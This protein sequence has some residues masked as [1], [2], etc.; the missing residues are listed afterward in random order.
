MNIKKNLGKCCV[1]LLLNHHLFILSNSHQKENA[2]YI[3]K[4]K[5]QYMPI[6]DINNNLLVFSTVCEKKKFFLYMNM[7]ERWREL[8]SKLVMGIFITLFLYFFNVLKSA[9][10]SEL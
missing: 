3:A 2:M 9:W 8:I 6:K 4:P 1:F 10:K 7:R 5:I